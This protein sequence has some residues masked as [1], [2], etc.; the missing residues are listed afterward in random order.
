MEQFFSKEG[1]PLPDPNE[2]N[3]SKKKDSASPLE[4]LLVE[5]SVRLEV[6]DVTPSGPTPLASSTVKVVEADVADS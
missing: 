6:T 3:D 5:S 4:E 1:L 2:D